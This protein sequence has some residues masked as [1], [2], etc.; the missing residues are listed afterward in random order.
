MKQEIIFQ[1]EL[2]NIVLLKLKFHILH[3]NKKI[4]NHFHIIYT[5]WNSMNLNEIN[6]YEPFIL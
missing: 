1:F 3:Y 2:N 5:K 6:N 4:K